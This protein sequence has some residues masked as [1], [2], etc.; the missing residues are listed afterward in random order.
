[1]AKDRIVTSD[2]SDVE[3]IL[4]VRGISLRRSLALNT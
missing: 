4:G 1:M 3:S 2:P